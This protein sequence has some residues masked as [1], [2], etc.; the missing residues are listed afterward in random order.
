MISLS[1]EDINLIKPV[2]IQVE[3]KNKSKV[4]AEETKEVDLP[5][6]IEP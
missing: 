1:E 6:S 3:L 2:S 4:L 5:H